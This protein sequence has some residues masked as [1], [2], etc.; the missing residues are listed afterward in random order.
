MCGMQAKEGLAYVFPYIMTYMDIWHVPEA[1]SM[2][3]K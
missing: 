2:F 1:G 3:L